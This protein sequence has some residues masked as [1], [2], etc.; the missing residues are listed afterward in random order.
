MFSHEKAPERVSDPFDVVEAVAELRTGEQFLKAAIGGKEKLDSF[1]RS[2]ASADQDE[3]KALEL[4]WTVRKSAL[5][6]VRRFERALEF[7]GQMDASMKVS[8]AAEA[9][10]AGSGAEQFS[11]HER[12][13]KLGLAR[14]LVASQ[15]VFTSEKSNQKDFGR[16]L[17][18]FLQKKGHKSAAEQAVNKNHLDRALALVQQLISSSENPKTTLV[19]L[20]QAEALSALGRSAEALSAIDEGFKVDAK[21][22]LLRSERARVNLQIRQ[23]CIEESEQI[24]QDMRD[25]MHRQL[26]EVPAES[27]PP[28]SGPNVEW[29]RGQLTKLGGMC[30][31]DEVAWDVLMRTKIGKV[32][33]SVQKAVWVD[34][35]LQSLCTKLIKKFR[36]MAERN[37]PLWG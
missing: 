15:H 18:N 11:E 25:E 31:R 20:A 3:E 23:A 26:E 34:A 9:G 33:A 16:D 22:E 1:D 21:D 24:V 10:S 19:Y 28:E 29:I 27:G 14:A 13:A 8:G 36:E 30:D 12:S 17:V 35:E 7:L 2:K 6:A 5:M 4:A 37:R 32:V